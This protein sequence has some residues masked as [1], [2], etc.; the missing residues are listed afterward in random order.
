MRSCFPLI[1]L[2]TPHRTCPHEVPNFTLLALTFRSS[3][4]HNKKGDSLNMLTVGE[5]H[6]NDTERD[7]YL[8]WE[9]RRVS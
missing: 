2:F 3:N 6:G 8:V 5:N 7:Y 9:N 4:Q 1:F